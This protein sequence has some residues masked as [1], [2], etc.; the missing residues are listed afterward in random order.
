MDTTTN[1]TTT[2]SNPVYENNYKYNRHTYSYG[3]QDEMFHI[4]VINDTTKCEYSLSLD[5]ESPIFDKNVI[6]NDINMVQRLLNDAFNN[7]IEVEKSIKNKAKSH[8]IAMIIISS[9]IKEEI[10][11]DIP[12]TKEKENKIMTE[13]DVDEKLSLIVDNMNSNT[14]DVIH[15][16]EVNLLK[17][18]TNLEER[19]R[20]LEKNNIEMV[21]YILSQPILYG[22]RCGPG[23]YLM[24]DKT[25][26]VMADE[27]HLTIEYYKHT[28]YLNSKYK[29]HNFSTI[30]MGYL[31]KLTDITLINFPTSNL[32]FLNC[33]ATLKHISLINMPQLL[34]VSRLFECRKLLW[35]KITHKSGIID[36]DI[37]RK[38]TVNPVL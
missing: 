5:N 33:T 8:Q 36:L 37:L 2:V 30:H 35:V 3:I 28:Y 21:R 20:F 4:F 38:K 11:I 31:K 22:I 13:N 32:D 34:S 19:I 7:C 9:Y 23:K 12:L 29:I 18:M 1:T 14:A 25:K 6:I 17:S 15:I 10:I 24:G 27:T 26:Y 16:Q